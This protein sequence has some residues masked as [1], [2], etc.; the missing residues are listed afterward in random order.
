[1]SLFERFAKIFLIVLQKIQLYKSDHPQTQKAFENL[2]PM[3]NKIISME[4][5]LVYIFS[6]DRVFV[7]GNKIPMGTSKINIV[8][9]FFSERSFN[10]F[11]ILRGADEKDV[12]LFL[13]IM[14]DSRKKT[15]EWCLKTTQSHNLDD[16]HFLYQISGNNF[17]RGGNIEA[18][19]VE[20]FQRDDNVGSGPRVVSEK[21][22]GKATATST[23]T[24]KMNIEERKPNKV[25]RNK[26]RVFTKINKEDVEKVKTNEMNI[27]DIEDKYELLPWSDL[28]YLEK[29]RRIANIGALPQDLI[30]VD[31]LELFE[32]IAY[33][34]ISEFLK[35]IDKFVRT[36][37]VDKRKEV[38]ISIIKKFKKL[39]DY[40]RPELSV[41]FFT[42]FKF[43]F[44]FTVKNFDSLTEE[45]KRHFI[46]LIFLLVDKLLKRKKY[47]K[48]KDIFVLMDKHEKILNIISKIK[49]YD[50]IEKLLDYYR[51]SK[52][53]ED[54]SPLLEAIVVL[55]GRSVQPLIQILMEEESRKIRR[56]LIDL[57]S[58]IGEQSIPYLK[59]LLI[60]DRWYVVRNGL[61]ILSEINKEIEL[62]NLK[63]ILNSE[64][65][66]VRKELVKYIK[67]VDSDELSGLL[68]E[69]IFNEPEKDLEKLAIKDIHQKINMEQMLDIWDYFKDICGNNDKIEISK[70]LIDE[71]VEFTVDI[72]PKFL[73]YLYS[74]FEFSTGF[75]LVSTDNITKIKMYTFELLKKEQNDIYQA[76]MKKMSISDNKEI[77]KFLKKV[78]L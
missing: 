9:K 24:K 20:N 45:F 47:E 22:I 6:N 69:L 3:V 32:N 27:S 77:K 5:D 73:K 48:V 50:Y 14:V 66:R 74:I 35:N 46:G 15:S 13:K 56:I 29:S 4:D 65:E 38:R 43:I 53:E 36:C 42:T 44:N 2:L 67:S 23:K 10:G 40:L 30:D 55:K 63:P 51:N 54:A 60:D 49:I 61:S 75:S 18:N 21:E 68:V 31:L 12:K 34:M 33:E 78:S 64:D 41:Q 25:K 72:E 70:L 16:I 58:D 62:E 52:V 8:E 76:F 37:L 1:M 17:V 11:Q 39:I 28:N 71:F 7:N 57:I 19:M 26:R 59:R